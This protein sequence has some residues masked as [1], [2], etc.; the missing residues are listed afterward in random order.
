MADKLIIGVDI[1]HGNESTIRTS[2][3]GVCGEVIEIKKIAPDEP[4]CTPWHI[5]R[6]PLCGVIFDAYA[7]K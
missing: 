4:I 1:V 7:L 2:Y 3:C 5:I 6:C